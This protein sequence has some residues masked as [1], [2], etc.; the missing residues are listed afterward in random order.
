[1]RP[2]AVKPWDVVFAT[3][4]SSGVAPRA[5]LCRAR[6]RILR[7]CVLCVVPPNLYI[8]TYTT[9]ITITTITAL[10]PLAVAIHRCIRI[11]IVKLCKPSLR[12]KTNDNLYTTYNTNHKLQQLLYTVHYT[13]LS[14]KVTYY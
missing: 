8:H 2:P 13:L 4:R 9:Y 10:A 14:I 1:M 11:V 3:R 5:G 6:I 7:A 12:G